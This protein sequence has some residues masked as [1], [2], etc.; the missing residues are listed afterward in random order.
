MP[1][2]FEQ[3]KFEEVKP[4][5]YVLLFIYFLQLF[6]CLFF[7]DSYYLKDAHLSRHLH[8]QCLETHLEQGVKYV[9]S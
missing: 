4:A 6:L 3:L 1:A 2:V 9:Q 7:G 5:S 8:A